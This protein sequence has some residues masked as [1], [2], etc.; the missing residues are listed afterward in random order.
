MYEIHL[1]PSTF[2]EP[3]EFLPERCI[4]TKS[5]EAT[6]AMNRDWAP[7]GKGSRACIARH[8]AMVEIYAA[9]EH[10]GR[11]RALEGA[12][13]KRKELDVMGW[14]NALVASDRVE[15]VWE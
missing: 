4:D 15:L 3:T 10:L 7:F 8:M 12:R 5:R 14:F 13:P 6:E 1:N 9:L 11:T 2:P